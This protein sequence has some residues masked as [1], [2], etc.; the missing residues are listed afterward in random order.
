MD[1]DALRAQMVLHLRQSGACSRPEVLN[2]FSKVKRESFFPTELLQH[3]YADDAFSIGLGQTI[4]QPSTIAIMLELL[5]AREG[6]SVLEIGAGSGYVC[7][8]L[9]HIVGPNG[10]VVGVEWLKELFEQARKNVQVEK[11]SNIQL[12]QGDGGLGWKEKAPFDKILVSCACPYIPKPLI[13][14]LKEG[15]RVVAPVGDPRAQ[16][17]QVVTKKGG[18]PVKLLEGSEL[19]EFF[20]FVPLMGKHGFRTLGKDAIFK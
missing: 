11:I 2:A 10:S 7:A 20:V 12:F 5:H 14:Q 18:K 1:F 17:L 9:A 8:L 16:Q 19:Y 3:A 13:E 6:D 15:G 4:S